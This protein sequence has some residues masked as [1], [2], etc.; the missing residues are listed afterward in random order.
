MVNFCAVISP[1]TYRSPPTPTPPVT[2]KAPVTGL[3]DG[4]AFVIVRIPA[5]LIPP[6]AMIFCPTPIP[7]ATVNAPNAVPDD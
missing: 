1:A 6:P 4:V 3:V 7:P 5:V 2:C